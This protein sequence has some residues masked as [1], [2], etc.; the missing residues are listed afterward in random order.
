M[1]W[2]DIG[3]NL[4]DQRLSIEPLLERANL[5]NVS[6]MMITGT[7]VEEST[8]AARLAQ[9][10]PGRLF[11]TAGIHPH[12]AKDAGPSYLEALRTLAD[13]PQVLAIGE[14]GL[15]FNRNFSPP[16]QQ[17]LVFEQ[18]LILA[19]ELQLPVFLHERD[20]FDAQISLL[21]KYHSSL[22]GGVVH[23]FTGDKQQMQAY[24]D[25]GF[26]IGI[27]GWVCDQKRGQALREAVAKLPL[28]RL[29][30]ETDAPYL[31]PKSLSP[32]ARKLASNNEPCYL[33]HIAEQLALLMNVQCSELQLHSLQNTCD[34]FGLDSGEHHAN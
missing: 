1:P 12:H 22:A 32:Q 23:C 7:N 13:L 15:D 10:H 4:M 19:S 34:L 27:T 5:A 2:F 24:L 11:S 20:A 18:Q 21:K 17:L 9:L 3:V 8:K 25:L 30:L 6:Q 14:C 29:L 33:P 26:Y 28:E 31:K 16:E